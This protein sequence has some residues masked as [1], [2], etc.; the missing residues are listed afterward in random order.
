[1]K[2]KLR[3]KLIM[4]LIPVL[5]VPLL[6][7]GAWHY[8]QQRQALLTRMSQD[9]HSALTDYQQRFEQQIHQARKD[10][11]LLSNS[12]LLRQYFLIKDSETRFY[13]MFRSVLELFKG[14]HQ[15][16]PDYRE[17]MLLNNAGR[18][19]VRFA[20]LVAQNRSEDESTQR[21]FQ[22][23]QQDRNAT[24]VEPVAHPDFGELMLMV[25]KS[26]PLS[27][28]ADGNARSRV[29][30]GGYLV[31]SLSLRTLHE[32]LAHIRIGDSGF[33]LILDKNG[34]PLHLPAA[35]QAVAVHL[36]ALHAQ[37]H[38]KDNAL[39]TVSDQGAEFL[40]QRHHLFA[41]YDLCAVWPLAEVNALAR[42]IAYQLLALLTI[43]TAIIAGTIVL[44]VHRLVEVPIRRLK[45]LSLQLASQQHDDSTQAPLDFSA[46]TRRDEIGDLANTFRTM[47]ENLNSSHQKLHRHAY[48]DNLTGLF[49]R[50]MFHNI[51]VK[52]IANAERHHQR[53]AV[54]FIDVDGFK[55]VNDTLGHNHGDVIL[56]EIAT[57]LNHSVRESDVLALRDDSDNPEPTSL[58]RF[59]GDEFSLIITDLQHVLDAKQVAERILA[60]MAQ[61]FTLE[62]QIFHLSASIG[63]ALFP[64]DGHEAGALLKNADIAMY[65]AK[66]QGKNQFEYFDPSMTRSAFLRHQALNELREA[67][68]TRQL[69]LYY[70]PQVTAADNELTGCE[71]LL[72]W[73]HPVRGMVSPAEFIP[74]AEE[75]GL[76][77]EIG[78]WVLEEACRQNQEWQQLGLKPIRVAVNFSTVQF[79]REANI[80]VL[81]QQTL[82]N[83]GL[84]ARYLDVEI[85]ETGIMQSHHVGKDRLLAIKR[86]GVT[87]SMDD[88]GTGYSSLASLRDFPIDK[89][90]V[91]KSFVDAI[92]SSDA[93]SAI[94]NAILALARELGLPVVAEGVETEP[95]LQ[96][97]R[98]QGCDYIQGYFISR[99][100]PAADM[101]RL[102]QQATPAANSGRQHSAP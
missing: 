93:G 38:P 43:V 88:F 31:L 78:R 9:M 85:T 83:T 46:F 29:D 63:I 79:N 51:L 2:L 44:L 28:Y 19:E 21:W 95:Q 14:F 10:L 15:T 20:D 77:V 97:L 47:A 39:Q 61:P 81:I 59:G 13:M 55:E 74:L 96:Y 7:L 98:K 54:L 69:C 18:E 8:H 101:T 76:I 75:S 26:V 64:E 58:A 53:L 6:L 65:Q 62:D 42:Q 5:L 71:A 56:Q 50:P 86:T 25:G 37:T 84:D 89:L 33:L 99:P 92:T 35:A 4:A 40:V 82:A 67:L 17:I 68:E 12:H 11:D 34:K 70:Q 87:I 80:A 57:R 60:A 52:A 45:N 49:N 1:M 48:F 23:L 36:P 30:H 73:K 66:A 22:H 91:D 3:S 90:K 102:L 72:R 41:G 16:E 32:A 24:V 94:M 27:S 100:L